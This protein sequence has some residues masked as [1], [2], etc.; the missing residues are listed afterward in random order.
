MA[1]YDD[2]IRINS[3]VGAA[4]DRPEIIRAALAIRAMKHWDEIV[5]ASMAEK[6]WPDKFDGHILW[7]ACTGSA[8]AQE[9]RMMRESILVKLNEYCESD[10]LFADVRFGVRP[11]KRI[12]EISKVEEVVAEFGT[13]S[14]RDIATNRLRNWSK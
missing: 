3:T 9:L 11:I 12:K 8:W 1:R 7:V 10:K 6:S 5:G 14:I 4:I 13:M 2:F